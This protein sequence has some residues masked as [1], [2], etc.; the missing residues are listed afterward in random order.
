MNLFFTFSELIVAWCGR[1]FLCNWEKLQKLIIEQRGPFPF[2]F[3]SQSFHLRNFLSIIA[4][5]LAIP[6]AIRRF[7]ARSRILFATE[8]RQ[9]ETEIDEKCRLLSKSKGSFTP[10]C[11]LWCV[12]VPE[13][14]QLMSICSAQKQL[15]QEMP[16]Q[17]LIWGR[18]VA[19]KDESTDKSIENR[20]AL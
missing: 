20:G 10:N 9:C 12:I 7:Y 4:R 6:V 19:Y 16:H 15:G 18:H 13:G 5:W 17:V 3:D 11:S 14:S 1:I 2:S 8:E